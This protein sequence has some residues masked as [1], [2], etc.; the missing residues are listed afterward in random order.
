M[1]RNLLRL[2]F[3]VSATLSVWNEVFIMLSFGD[4]STLFLLSCIIQGLF[5]LSST[6]SVRTEVWRFFFS[7]DR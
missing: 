7:S 5:L 6:L 3:L 1:S 4:V 2:R